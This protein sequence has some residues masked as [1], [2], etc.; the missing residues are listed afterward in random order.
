M[1]GVGS[2]LPGKILTNEDIPGY[3]IRDDKWQSFWGTDRRYS[4]RRN[5]RVLDMAERSALNALDMAGLTPDLID[6]IVSCSSNISELDNDNPSAMFPKIGTLVRKKLKAKNAVAYDVESGCSGFIVGMETAV[7]FMQR[8]P[9]KRALVISADAASKV[10]DYSI[11]SG[12]IFGDGSGAAVLDSTHGIKG[13]LHSSIMTDSTHN[14]Q[15][16]VYWNSVYCNKNEFRPLFFVNRKLKMRDYVPAL[17]PR[18]VKK[19]LGEA[20]YEKEDVGRF[21]LHQPGRYILNQWK[22]RLGLSH[23]TA[24]DIHSECACLSSSSVSVTLDRV[25]RGEELLPGNNFVIAGVGVG[26][27][28]GAHLW[29]WQGPGKDM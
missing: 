9:F 11:P 24:P 14:K 8:G 27:T 25:I 23:E 5:E 2:Y 21:I 29:K 15:A 4:L 1:T 28:W 12:V 6:I 16:G 19:L 13:Y 10:L 26:W 7:R 3:K 17:I 20:N 18:V 22:E